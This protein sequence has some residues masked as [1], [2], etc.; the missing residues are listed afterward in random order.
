M[1]N[2]RWIEKWRAPHKNKGKPFLRKIAIS[3]SYPVRITYRQFRGIKIDVENENRVK[4]LNSEND[5]INASF[6]KSPFSS[7][8]YIATQAPM[9]STLH[10]FWLMIW[11]QKCHYIVMLTDL[12]HK[13]VS[14]TFHL[15]Q[16]DL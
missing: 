12:H 10:D 16:A 13:K 8:I 15:K 5:Y 4:L 9:I 2:R 6:L 11:E 3:M 1:P 7:T 14:F